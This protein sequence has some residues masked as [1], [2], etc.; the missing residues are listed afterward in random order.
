M[1]PLPPYPATRFNWESV[2]S[3]PEKQGTELA[4]LARE[5]RPF[6][7]ME[8]LVLWYDSLPYL[9]LSRTDELRLLTALATAASSEGAVSDVVR[10]LADAEKL[11]AQGN[12]LGSLKATTSIFWRAL[13]DFD[14]EVNRPKNS[15]PE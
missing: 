8:D 4:A 12:F 9:N 15:A 6:E 13:K 3:E 7:D 1:R 10:G 5:R 14:E 11:R 2:L